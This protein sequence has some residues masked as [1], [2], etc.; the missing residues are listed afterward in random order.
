[1]INKHDRTYNC[2]VCYAPTDILH[3]IYMG[4][5]KRQVS[6]SYNL[7]APLCHRHHLVM[8]GTQRKLNVME[9]TMLEELGTMSNGTKTWQQVLCYLMKLPHAEVIRLAINE[10]DSD[11]L[12][13]IAG[14]GAISLKRLEV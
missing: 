8:H 9:T 10:N 14:I 12:G 6:I 2:A 1:M 7:Q 5:H 4:S 13:F 3:E 11:L